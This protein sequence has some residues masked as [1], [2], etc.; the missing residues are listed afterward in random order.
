[1]YILYATFCV[2]YQRSKCT[3]LS[4]LKTPLKPDHPVHPDRL[5]MLKNV[6]NP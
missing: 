2:P 3:P 4:P 6:F 1:M 5:L